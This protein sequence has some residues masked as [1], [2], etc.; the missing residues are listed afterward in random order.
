MKWAMGVIVVSVCLLSGCR[1]KKAEQTEAAANFDT[2]AR[3]RLIEKIAEQFGTVAEFQHFLEAG[4]AIGERRP[5]VSLEDF[6]EGNTDYGSIGCN[7]TP[8]LGPARFYSTLKGIRDRDDVQD[9]LVEISMIEDD[10]MWPFSESIWII[11]S[12]SQ[13]EV[14]KWM[15]PLKPDEI[16]EG[17]GDAGKP[18]AA[19]DPQPGMK[20]Y[21]LW[22]D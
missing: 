22:W 1:G 18:R 4:C 14:W 13:Q 8:M 15:Q 17:W 10:S 7:L 6:F 3:E 20:V 9:V 19:P 11:S 5:A 12:A 2:A 16:W 21:G